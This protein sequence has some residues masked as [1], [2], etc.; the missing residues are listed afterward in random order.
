MRDLSRPNHWRYGTVRPRPRNSHR[1]RPE[2]QQQRQL[3][4][5]L[6]PG[7]AMSPTVTGEPVVITLP[8]DEIGD[9]EALIREARARQRR[10]QLRLAAALLALAAAA[11]IAAV[12]NSGGGGAKAIERV[13]NGPA[14]NVRAFSHHGMLAFISH[15]K[16]W[17]L[18]GNKNSLVPLPS[19]P[20]FRPQQ[21]T[22][23][24]DG[25]WLAYLEQHTTASSLTSHLWLAR[26][27][28]RD[29]HPVAAFQTYTL[30]GWR[31]AAGGSHGDL[32]A[33]AAG[34]RRP[35]T[36]CPCGTP[37]TLRLVTPDGSS[38]VI[39]RAFWIYGAAWS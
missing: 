28:G 31:P 16:L 2:H 36:N 39:A 7:S 6:P 8:H 22:F 14:V 30:I 29:A 21:P 35:S 18:D 37:T 25:K 10:R 27:D 33:V 12:I 11:S 17:L 4:G 19:P 26:A 32:L 20:G 38:R 5:H 3:D 23:S 34:G 15:G 13:P 24:A 9:P 1:R